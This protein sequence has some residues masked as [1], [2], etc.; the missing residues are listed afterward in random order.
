MENR[1]AWTGAARGRALFRLSGVLALVLLLVPLRATLYPDMTIKIVTM[2]CG[3]GNSETSA[4]EA[5][6]EI[7]RG[8]GRPD[9]VFLQEPRMTA[10]E[11]RRFYGYGNAVVGASGEPAYWSP[12]VLTDYPVRKVWGV[13]F[14]G[15]FEGRDVATCALLEIEGEPCLAC[16]VHL[17]HVAAFQRGADQVVETDFVRLFRLIWGELFRETHRT[18]SIRRILALIRESGASSVILG[19]DFN[20]I[21]PSRTIRAVRE[22]YEDTLGY[23]LEALGGTFRKIDFPIKPRID[24]IFHSRDW[25]CRESSILGASPGDHY[26]VRAVLYRTGP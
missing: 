2:N 5:V 22:E 12:A 25:R 17:E 20:T 3:D 24:F 14:D 13:P 6:R 18:A 9:I 26:P 15:T 11:M 7:L 19:G 1:K 10:G 21:G 4:Y 16:S 23:G 8:Q